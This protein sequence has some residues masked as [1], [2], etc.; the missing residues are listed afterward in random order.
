MAFDSDNCFLAYPGSNTMF[1]IMYYIYIIYRSLKGAFLGDFLFF[2]YY[3]QH[4]FICRLSDSTVPT[5][6]GIEP[7]AVVTG[8]LAVR[9]SNH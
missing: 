6:A 5:D 1:D 8:A 2:T 4:R 7:R 9:R 3:I